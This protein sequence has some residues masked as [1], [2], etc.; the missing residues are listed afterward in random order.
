MAGEIQLNSTTLATESSGTI[1]LSNVDSATNRT[2]LGLGSIATQAAD[3]VSI[4]GGNITGGTIGSGVVFPAGKIL[5][6][7]F[8]SQNRG[9]SA[10]SIT[11]NNTYETVN[12]GTDSNA[13]EFSFTTTSETT[14]IYTQVSL[15]ASGN[16]NTRTYSLRTIIS[17]DSFSTTVTSTATEDGYVNAISTTNYVN[18]QNIMSLF[19]VDS[20]SS[21]KLRI[22]GKCDINL[23][24]LKIQNNTN[25]DLLVLE[26]K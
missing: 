12:N 3:S 26:Y 21:Y 25:F 20:S 13:L 8:F 22:Q 18:R 4:S 1:T 10:H 17:K 6:I 19:N 16:S 14:K 2:N 11:T 9:S 7:Q 5:N 15:S 23:G 24:T